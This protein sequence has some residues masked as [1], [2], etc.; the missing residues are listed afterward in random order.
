MPVED[1]VHLAEQL[2]DHL[3]ASP[4]K[5]SAGDQSPARPAADGKRK[6]KRKAQSQPEAELADAEQVDAFSPRSNER[7]QNIHEA[8]PP[9]EEAF[10]SCR[11][12]VK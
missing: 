1:L 2:K 12:V 3:L 7:W 11:I 5:V 4:P 6:V 8:R 10:M 9:L